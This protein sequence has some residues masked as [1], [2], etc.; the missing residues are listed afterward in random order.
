M[1]A[2]VVRDWI[3]ILY[4]SIRNQRDFNDARKLAEKLVGPYASGIR[5]V[6][7]NTYRV[8]NRTDLPIAIW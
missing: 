7:E 2:I 5:I 6:E 8:I 4:V 3:P 1:R